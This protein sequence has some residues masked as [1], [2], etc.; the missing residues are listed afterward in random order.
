MPTF[1]KPSVADLRHAAD[2]LGMNPS[3]FYLNAVQDI[4]GPLCAAYAA[5]DAVPDEKPTVKYPRDGWR[6]PSPDENKLGAWYVK[7]AI[8]GAPSGRLAGYR[9]ALKDNICLA[10]VPMMVGAGFLDGSIP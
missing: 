7:T 5:L 4:V 9:V 8:K 6:K 1:E 2:A 3:M 10:G